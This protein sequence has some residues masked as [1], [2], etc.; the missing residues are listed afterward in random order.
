LLRSFQELSRVAAGFD[1]AH[2]L[3]LHISASWGESADLKALDQRINRILDTVRSVPGVEAA[4]TASTLP[5]IPSESKAELK[6][7]EGAQDPNR[8]VI[9]DNRFV[10]AGSFS[11]MRIAML[12]GEACNNHSE[13]NA[14]V[15]NRNFA[16][17]YFPGSSAIGHH[18]ALGA[19]P[20]GLTAEIRGIAASAREQGLASEPMPT[21]YW[22]ISAPVPDP[23]YLIRTRGE[24]MSMAGTLRRVIHQVEPSRSV[25]D[26]AP[27]QDRLSDASAENRMRTILLSLFALTAISLACIGLYGTVSYIVAVRH[28]EIGL[29]LALGARRRQIVNRYLGQGMRVAFIGCACGL[30][31]FAAVARLL[32]SMLFGISSFDPPTF[33]AIVLLVLTVAAAAA[34]IPA[35]RAART[36]PMKVLRDQ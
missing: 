24:P 31:I 19:A 16:D 12:S 10:S 35:L 9:A 15:V 33:L 34:F 27:L 11:V 32:S 14:V 6:I 25:F 30:L 8:P 22:C 23:N 26:I 1:P 5:G 36:D 4:A 29:R 20:T 7:V 28:R 3:T 18:L 2:V 17:R 13:R 21:A